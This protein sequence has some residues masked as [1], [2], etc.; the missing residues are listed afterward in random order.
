[1]IAL[2]ESINT[3]RKGFQGELDK[4]KAQIEVLDNEKSEVISNYEKDRILWENKIAFL[5]QQKEQAKIE[6]SEKIRKLESS[7]DVLQRNRL[8]EKSSTESQHN[9]YVSKIEKKYLAQISE[10]NETNT[11]KTMEFE[12]TV[13]ELQLQLKNANEKYMLDLHSKMGNVAATEKRLAELLENDKKNQA[14][15]ERLRAEKDQ[16]TF[17]FQ[18]QL[19]QEKETM[20]AKVREIE[21]QLKNMEKEKREK[22]FEYEREM[23][24]W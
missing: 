14:E 24:K 10:L 16:R 2:K 21:D 3:E 5:E 13:R 8:N 4:L 17:E 18:K 20:R 11:K 19:E 12:S 7:I 9:E 23:S 15:L 1:M 22:Y 6:T